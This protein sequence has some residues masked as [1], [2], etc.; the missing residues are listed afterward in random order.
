MTFFV[1]R[2]KPFVYFVDKRMVENVLELMAQREASAP[3]IFVAVDHDQPSATTPLGEARDATKVQIWLYLDFDAGKI[4]NKADV[5]SRSAL[6]KK[7]Q[8]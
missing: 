8:E 5:N 6:P 7:L 2:A 1:V 4:G 3:L